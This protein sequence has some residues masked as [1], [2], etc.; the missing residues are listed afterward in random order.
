MKTISM[1]VGSKI[2]AKYRERE[3]VVKMKEAFSHDIALLN[4]LIHQNS[5][6]K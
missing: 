5:K 3:E 6:H 4:L 2:F 1:L